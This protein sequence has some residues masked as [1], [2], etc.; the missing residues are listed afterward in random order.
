MPLKYQWIFYFSA[1]KSQSDEVIWAWDK[2]VA[3]ARAE[4]LSR[5]AQWA[6]AMA[7]LWPTGSTSS[8][9][10]VIH[11]VGAGSTWCGSLCGIR[12]G[13][14]AAFVI[15]RLTLKNFVSVRI[16]E[17]LGYLVFY[18]QYSLPEETVSY[19]LMP[20]ISVYL[21]IH[22]PV[23]YALDYDLCCGSNT[24]WIWKGCI[25]LMGSSSHTICFSKKPDQN[26]EET[27]C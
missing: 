1:R 16:E 22:G 11:L 9:S 19:V 4:T 24:S 6:G 7:G 15:S 5:V 17:I 2:E 26:Q 18:S 8:W 10:T 3:E 23:Q 27:W 21:Y 20:H 12:V 13:F 14:V 25:V